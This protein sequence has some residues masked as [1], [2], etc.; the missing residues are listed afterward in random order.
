[1]VWPAKAQVEE[2]NA[3]ENLDGLIAL[4]RQKKYLLQRLETINRPPAGGLSPVRGPSIG[5]STNIQTDLPRNRYIG[6]MDDV[7][8]NP[9][10]NPR[11]LMRTNKRKLQEGQIQAVPKVF[12]ERL[13]TSCNSLLVSTGPHT[14]WR[15]RTR[16]R[17]KRMSDLHLGLLRIQKSN[18][19][20]NEHSERDFSLSHRYC[21]QHARTNLF[22]QPRP[23]GNILTLRKVFNALASFDLSEFEECNVRQNKTTGASI[24]CQGTLL[25][26]L[27]FRF[28]SAKCL[29]ETY[30]ALLCNYPMRLSRSCAGLHWFC[31]GFWNN[32]IKEN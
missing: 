19:A 6:R 22:I 20:W 30:T 5:S 7:T 18:Q 11:G 14:R 15:Q 16:M 23:S 25:Q 17:S 8:V 3:G 2:I 9:C 10:G 24:W 12:Y 28:L 29:N 27:V 32:L 21:R 1:M 4:Y 26:G 31:N 13:K